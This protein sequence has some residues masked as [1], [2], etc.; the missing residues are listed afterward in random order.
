MSLDGDEMMDESQTSDD[1]EESDGS[2]LHLFETRFNSLLVPLGSSL[3]DES[4]ILRE[5]PEQIASLTKPFLSSR[6]TMMSFMR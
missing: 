2:E 3:T 6:S 5:L 4:R 1:C